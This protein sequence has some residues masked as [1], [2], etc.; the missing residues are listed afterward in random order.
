MQSWHD[1]SKDGT[2]RY[3]V[4]PENNGYRVAFLMMAQLAIEMAVNQ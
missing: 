4:T 2:L 3:V 1:I